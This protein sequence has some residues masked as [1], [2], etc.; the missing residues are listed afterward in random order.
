MNGLL[1]S[2]SIQDRTGRYQKDRSLERIEP[3][4]LP[5]NARPRNST[6]GNK[7]GAKHLDPGLFA[8]CKQRHGQDVEDQVGRVAA[9]VLSVAI[10]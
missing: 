4:V 9:R 6:S 2:S 10:R 5:R 1:K 8:H 3:W 7:S